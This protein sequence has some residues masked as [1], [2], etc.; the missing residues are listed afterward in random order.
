[1][2]FSELDLHFGLWRIPKEKFKAKRDT[3]IPLL[4]EVIVI[5]KRRQKELDSNFVF[6]S[7]RKTI[8]GHITEPKRAWHNL[9][10][11]AG[12]SERF[13]LHDLRRTIASYQAITGSSTKL[14]GASLGN[15]TEKSVAIYARLHIS[16]VKNS[17]NNANNLIQ[18]VRKDPDAISDILK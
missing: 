3:I 6:P 13:T 10:E 2:E 11:R 15:S 17:M 4:D 7:P 1:M 8:K 16:S 18:L 14:I 5:L 9:I 12:I